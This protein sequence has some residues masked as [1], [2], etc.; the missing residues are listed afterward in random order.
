M[1]YIIYNY[2]FYLSLYM[3]LEFLN[4]LEVLQK[5]FASQALLAIPVVALTEPLPVPQGGQIDHF[6][7]STG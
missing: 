4:S 1:E 7:F 2:L 5:G 3:T 6:S